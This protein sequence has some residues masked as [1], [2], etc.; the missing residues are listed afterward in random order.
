VRTRGFGAAVEVKSVERI[1]TCKALERTEASKRA[2]ALVNEF[3]TKATEVLAESEVNKRRTAEGKKPAN[4]LLLRDASDHIPVVPSFKEK[5][6]IDGVALVEMPAEVGIARILGMKEVVLSDHKDL[7]RK[8][9]AFNRE[10]TDGTLVY[11]HIKGPDE[12]GHDGDAVGKK[13]N[14]E[15]ID[16]VFFGTIAEAVRDCKMAVSADHSTPAVLKMHS[17]DPV[18]LLVTSEERDPGSCRFTE[19]DAAN[20]SLGKIAGDKVLSTTFAVR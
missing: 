13:K 10:L 1:Q 17:S 5:H 6:G 15:Q 19:A 2:A 20:G 14:I 16:D 11:A 4:L 9:E 8:A 18:P 12:F 3:L 7:R